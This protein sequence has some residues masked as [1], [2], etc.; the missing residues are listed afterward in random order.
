[1]KNHRTPPWNLSNMIHT[2]Y[3]T[4]YITKEYLSFLDISINTNNTLNFK[5]E[6]AQKYPEHEILSIYH[7]PPR[8]ISNII[9]IQNIILNHGS[10]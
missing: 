10:P 1:M 9:F 5:S 8:N 6:I 7:I 4:S 3:H 2:K